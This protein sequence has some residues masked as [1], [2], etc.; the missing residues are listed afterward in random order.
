MISVLVT[1]LLAAAPVQAA[2]PAAA[3]D[4][5]KDRMVCKREDATGSRMGAKRI[6]RTASE[7]AEYY[8]SI[9]PNGRA[10]DPMGSRAQGTGK[11]QSG[12][13]GM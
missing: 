7:W 4:A 5:K 12:Y 8:K 6:C 2:P 3:A 1:A 10:L 11:V 13:P 9:D